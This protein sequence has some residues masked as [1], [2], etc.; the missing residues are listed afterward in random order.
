MIGWINSDDTYMPGAVST[1]IEYLL[2]HPLIGWVYGD[3]Y[4]IDE[5][6]RII[7]IWKSR[8]FDL[9][10]LVCDSYYII[11][12]TVFFRRSMFDKVGFLDPDLHFMMDVDFFYRLGVAGRA[13]YI[14]QILATRRLHDQAKSVKSRTQFTADSIET[15]H[16]LF[17][18]PDL[19]PELAQSKGQA[20]SRVFFYGGCWLFAE[21]ESRQA[22]EYLWKS[23][24]ADLNPSRLR[25]MKTL[26]LLLQSHI[27]IRWYVPG[28]RM[29][30]QQRHLARKDIRVTWTHDSLERD[31]SLEILTR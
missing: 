28:R 16:K 14:P 19:P 31:I 8:R 15:L 17:D 24:R 9:K 10:H 5:H 6:S 30:A 11:Q 1:A 29:Q 18:N 13:G 22:C 23:L 25:T 12:P 7:G 3:G 26:I 20:Y 21:G 2:E 27:G 4:W